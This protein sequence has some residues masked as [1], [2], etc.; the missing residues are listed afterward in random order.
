VESKREYTERIER[1]QLAIE[2][3]H[4]CRAKHVGTDFVDESFEGK[5]IWVGEVEVFSLNGHSKAEK[6]YAWTYH[7]DA[8]EKIATVLGIRPIRSASAA[9]RSHIGE[10]NK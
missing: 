5:P 9:V 6:C 10:K 3:L 1:L 7:G 4:N 8:G 2:H